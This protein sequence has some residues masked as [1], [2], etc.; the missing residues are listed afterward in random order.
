MVKLTTQKGTLNA[1]VTQPHSTTKDTLLECERKGNS[2]SQL[3]EGRG[4][5]VVRKSGLF[6][7]GPKTTAHPSTGEGC[8]VEERASEKER[9]CPKEK[10]VTK[11]RKTL[12]RRGEG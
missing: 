1:P 4:R 12:P 3:Q 8:M 2:I 11:E 10:W 9:G 6:V 5:I 7:L